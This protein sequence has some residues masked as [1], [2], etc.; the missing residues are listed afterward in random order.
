MVRDPQ[1]AHADGKVELEVG[2][3]GAH[4]CAFVLP[5]NQVVP[6]DNDHL[7]GVAHFKG[8]D[9]EALQR[10][11]MDGKKRVGRKDMKPGRQGARAAESIERRSVD[12]TPGGGSTPTWRGGGR[13]E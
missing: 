11:A 3:D 7:G 13:S 12:N 4:A 5:Q 6:V 1:Q 9:V 10:R 8:K 2:D